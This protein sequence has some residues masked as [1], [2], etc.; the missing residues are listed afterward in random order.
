MNTKEWLATKVFV[1]IRAKNKCENCGK[2]NKKIKV[3]S[4]LKLLHTRNTLQIHHIELGKSV[5][6]TY[7]KETGKIGVYKVEADKLKLLCCT[8]HGKEH[9]LQKLLNK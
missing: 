6:W 5:I 2:K 9:A 8:C 3:I 1:R 4:K 7:F